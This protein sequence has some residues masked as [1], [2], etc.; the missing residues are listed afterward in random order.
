MI[1]PH[2]RPLEYPALWRDTFVICISTSRSVGQS[3]AHN[4]EQRLLSAMDIID[5]QTHAVVIAE[6]KFGDVAVQVQGCSTLLR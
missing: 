2:C 6:V 1:D 3:L 5:T 4:S